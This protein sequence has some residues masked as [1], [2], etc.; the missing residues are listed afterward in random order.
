M[1]THPDLLPCP[2]CGARADLDVIDGEGGNPNDGGH[3]I[4][5][6]LCRASTPLRFACGDDPKP[7]L[8]EAWNRRAAPSGEVAAPV[9]ARHLTGDAKLAHDQ[10]RT[11]VHLARAL[12]EVHSARAL[13]LAAG[14][15]PV[16]IIGESSAAIM[17]WLGDVLNNM[18]A[19]DDA[20]E[21]LDPIFDAAHA[22]WQGL[23]P[24]ALR[25]P[26][27]TGAQAADLT[28]EQCE[29]ISLPIYASDAIMSADDARVQDWALIRAGYRAARPV[30]AA[31]G[32]ASDA[33]RYRLLRRKVVIVGSEF[34][35][36]N[37]R[38]RYVAPD[39]AVE[40]D[41]ALDESLA[42][43]VAKTAAQC[44]KRQGGRHG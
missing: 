13:I 24:S 28:D 4:E 16:E 26:A 33:A 25:S 1:S 11:V 22:R 40:L 21:W 44:P 20:D 30:V 43:T 2:F 3:Y 5:C 37:I 27:G 7:L 34:C 14:Q 29:A 12:A 17:D 35:V 6:S 41:A 19:V 38:P 10:C 36:L 32:D 39:A 31:E 18:D 23:A 8:I 42:A 15:G 9:E